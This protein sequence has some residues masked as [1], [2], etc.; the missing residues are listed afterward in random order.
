MQVH[1]RKHE[2]LIPY[3]C[4]CGK[5]YQSKTK[6]FEHRKYEH[7]SRK[8]PRSALTPSQPL[9][10]TLRDLRSHI[11]SI[12]DE[13]PSSSLNVQFLVG[14]LTEP[15]AET[16]LMDEYEPQLRAR[17]CRPSPPVQ[18]ELTCDIGIGTEDDP[19]QPLSA[20]TGSTT[21]FTPLALPYSDQQDIHRTVLSTVGV[22]TDPPALT[23]SN[24]VGVCTELQGSSQEVN[25][26]SIG[27]DPI[28]S[29]LESQT[30]H[31]PTTETRSIGLDPMPRL[32]HHSGST[33]YQSNPMGVSIEAAYST[34]PYHESASRSIGLDPITMDAMFSH[35]QDTLESSPHQ[36]DAGTDPIDWLFDESRELQ[37]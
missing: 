23:G 4:T 26:Q 2:G 9:S 32:D 35:Q 33:I 11:S 14:L 19:F 10:S 15:S 31:S 36:V 8:R 6:Y 13:T 16:W 17:L 5:E 30:L 3:K 29:R 12:I 21:D 1:L 24:T 18:S 22:N 37:L 28:D 7:S 20:T 25:T 27:L 34:L